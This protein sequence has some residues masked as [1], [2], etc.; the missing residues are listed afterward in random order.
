[1]CTTS[2]TLHNQSG[3]AE[4]VTVTHSREAAVQYEFYI[5]QAI[6]DTP[7]VQTF[8]DRLLFLEPSATLFN[9]LTGIWQSKAEETRVYRLILSGQFQRSNVINTLR[10]E[11]GV[12]MAGLSQTPQHQQNFMYAETEIQ[13]NKAE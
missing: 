11:I 9:G 2:H 1:M 8:L 4:H 10:Q 6:W 12:L 3:P 7:P 13:M 5:P